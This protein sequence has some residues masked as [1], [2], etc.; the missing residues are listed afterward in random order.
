MKR[1]RRSIRDEEEEGKAT[2]FMKHFSYTRQTQSAKRGRRRGR[3]DEEG[4][5]E[6]EWRRGEDACPKGRMFADENIIAQHIVAQWQCVCV[7]VRVCVCVCTCVCVC[8]CWG[9]GCFWQGYK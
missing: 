2:L 3:R 5:E 9:G 4:E 1:G 8:V 6:E 7:C